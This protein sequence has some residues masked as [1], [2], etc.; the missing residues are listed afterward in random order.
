MCAVLPP[1]DSLAVPFEARP[2]DIRNSNI[3]MDRTFSGAIDDVI[4]RAILADIRSGKTTVAKQKL[5]KFLATDPANVTGLEMLGTILLNEEKHEQAEK[6]LSQ[7]AKLAP[8][9][10]S[11]RTRLGVVLLN[12]QK[13]ADAAP[14]LQFAVER[15]PGNI[16]ALTNYGWLLIQLERHRDAL[17]I[18][19]H[20]NKKEFQGKVSKTDVFVG[21]AFLYQQL[22]RPQKT[23]AL[24]Q[25]ELDRTKERHINNRI[26]L[27]LIDAYLAEKK[28]DKAKAALAAVARLVP[29]THV[30]PVLA[31]ARLLA[32]HGQTTQAE[33][34]LNRALKSHPKN[35]ADIQIELARLY[36][37]RKYY[38][39][40]AKA[41]SAAAS[42]ARGTERSD[43]LAE[44]TSTFAKANRRADTLPV[45]ERF[46]TLD[47]DNA[48]IALMLAKTLGEARRTNEALTLLD[49]LIEKHPK[50]GPAYFQ[51]AVILR[52]DKKLKAAMA[53]MRASV[54]HT[55]GNPIAWQLLADLSHDIHGDASMVGVLR[56]GLK[57][58][59]TDPKLLLG[60][61]SLA[62][63]EG[64]L[65]EAQEMF[66]RMVARYPNDPQA[67]SNAAL[68][69]LDLGESPEK[70]R[71]LLKRAVDIAPRV[72]AIADTWGWMLHKLGSS[73][74][75]I[76]LLLRVAKAIPDDGGVQYHLGAAYEG[77]NENGRA[78]AAFRKALALG[79]PKHY[80]DDVV[81]RLTRKK[82]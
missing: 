62:Y 11:L 37:D 12:R 42:E 64:L 40:A 58:N 61:G 51:K 17:E 78:R 20:L 43:I 25:S 68:A 32:A 39:R 10:V 16:L 73:R 56:E 4:L 72:P 28:L 5:V 22:N 31:E 26:F 34:Q 44:F 80:K 54:T 23:I 24:L 60:V 35:K 67:L 81:K 74:E 59:P 71:E 82:Q 18:Y 65:V 79:V 30:G 2:P 8:Q 76:K 75:A 70:A 57:H 77:I 21:L 1:S 27:N 41:Y 36:I 9:Q 14:H 38:R 13:F 53:A 15:E 19:E 6:I 7:A 66:D 50:L 52:L 47:G 48:D 33:K 3:M 49:G 55:P 45:L 46:A 69:S 29:Q 63:S